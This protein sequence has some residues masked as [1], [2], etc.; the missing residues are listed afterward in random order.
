MTYH[1]KVLLYSDDEHDLTTLQQKDVEDHVTRVISDFLQTAQHA[2]KIFGNL[3]ES[4]DYRTIQG[5]RVYEKDAALVIQF[6][7]TFSDRDLEIE[8]YGEVLDGMLDQTY[9][10]TSATY[11]NFEA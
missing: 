7:G 8:L 11:Y 2:Q 1:L 4:F 6:L 5:F 10:I 9:Y 3:T